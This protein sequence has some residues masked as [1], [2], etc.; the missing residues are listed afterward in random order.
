MP[1]IITYEC[2]YCGK[3]DE[4]RIDPAPIRRTV[5]GKDAE[6]WQGL[7]KPYLIFS[8]YGLICLDC[9]WKAN[10]S[11]WWAERGRK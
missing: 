4:K 6:S 8:V 1:K 9:N 10:L 7:D 11:E 5:H 2:D 3:I